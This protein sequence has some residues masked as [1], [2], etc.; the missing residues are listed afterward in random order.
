MTAIGFQILFLN[1]LGRSQ[2]VLLIENLLSVLIISLCLLVIVNYYFVLLSI[3]CLELRLYNLL[4]KLGLF[5]DAGA[6]SAVV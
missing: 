6:A 5:V 2:L 3:L 4:V 1:F